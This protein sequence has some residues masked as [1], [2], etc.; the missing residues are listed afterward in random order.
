VTHVLPLDRVQAA[1][2]M[3]ETYSGGAGKV[4]LKP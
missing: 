4:V 3:L 2:E 1:F